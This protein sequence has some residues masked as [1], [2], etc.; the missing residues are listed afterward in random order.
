MVRIDT[1]PTTST[2]K[3]PA[4]PQA[5]SPLKSRT[6]SNGRSPETNSTLA[7]VR[8]SLSLAE[9]KGLL[10][11]PRTLVVRARM[12]AELVE[13]AKRKTGITS[14]SRLL[15]AAL[16]NIAF[17]DDYMEWLSSQRGTVSANHDLEF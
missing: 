7:A 1:A 14:D 2:P 12:P 6:R 10:D 9:E 16:A 17:A 5:K 3:N 4:G 15:E 13:E 8:G 11:G